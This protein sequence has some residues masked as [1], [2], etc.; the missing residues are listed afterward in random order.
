L[1]PTQTGT[2]LGIFV[3]QWHE[4]G[5]APIPIHTSFVAAP[6]PDAYKIAGDALLGVYYMA[7]DYDRESPELQRFFGLYQQDHGRPPSI[8]FHTAGTVDTLNMLQ[9]YL[10]K[11]PE[12]TRDG[13]KNYLLSEIKEYRGMM[14]VYSFDAEG[15]ANLG[16]SLAQ[17]TRENSGRMK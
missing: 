17:I 11:H 13:F 8:P 3:K 2:A 15:N 5:A 10:D 14:G 9:T 12:Y 16:F 7:P 4:Q 1:M 6:N